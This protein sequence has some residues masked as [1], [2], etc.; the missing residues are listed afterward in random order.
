MNIP[1]TNYQIVNYNHPIK[2]LGF[3]I[4]ALGLGAMFVY[5]STVSLFLL[6]AWVFILGLMIW[7]PGKQQEIEGAAT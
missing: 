6:G 4:C 7:V 1:F 5:Y 2:L 3:V